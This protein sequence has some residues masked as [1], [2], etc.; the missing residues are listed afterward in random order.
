MIGCHTQYRCEILV[1]LCIAHDLVFLPSH[2]LLNAGNLFLFQTG[3]TAQW[4]WG[5]NSQIYLCQLC[6][7]MPWCTLPSL[8]LLSVV[9]AGVPF[10]M[11]TSC[12][13]LGMKYIKNFGIMG[14]DN[15]LSSDKGSNSS[16][17]EG[18]QLNFVVI[19]TEKLLSFSRNDIMWLKTSMDSLCCCVFQP[20]DFQENIDSRPHPICWHAAALTWCMVCTLACIIKKLCSSTML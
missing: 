9:N 13:Y 14:A 2:E 8:Y 4:H 3:P 18:Q 15:L 19:D 20:Q 17:Q 10:L 12:M 6:A 7:M 1:R 16:F 11:F 5:D